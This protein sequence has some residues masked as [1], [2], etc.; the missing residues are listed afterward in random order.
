MRKSR[1]LAS[2]AV[3]G[4][5]MTACSPGGDS[6]A[7]STDDAG[8][9][10]SAAETVSIWYL[11]DAVGVEEAID[12]FKA[13][14]PD[15]EVD[16]QPYANDQYK[17]KLKVALGTENGPDVFHTWGGG[18]FKT[19]VDAG[20][21][22]DLGE[23]G[24]ETGGI[25]EAALKTGEFDGTQ[26]AVPVT[27]EASMV[28]YRTDV[29]EQLSLTPPKTWPEFL[30]VIAQTKDAGLV[31]I[32]MA[33]KPRWPGTHW[34]SELVAQSCGPDFVQQVTDGAASFDDPCVVKAH[35]HIQELVDAGAFNEG[36]NGLDYDPGE[37]R[38]LFWSGKAAMNHMGNWTVG[39]A[40][41]EAPEV[42]EKMAMFTLPAIPDAK[43]SN[44]AMTGG[45]NLFAIAEATENKEAATALLTELTGQEHA[46]VLAA[47]GRIPVRD[48]VEVDDPLLQQ[49]ADAMAEAPALTPWPDQ[50][51]DPTVAEVLLAQTQ[52]LFGKETTPE[53]AAQALAD[54]QA[55]VA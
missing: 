37:S 5:L 12:R 36:F 7:T 25:S 53:A 40:R 15:V 48:G 33:N 30:D 19:Y 44:A 45:T 21:V 18:E 8:G 4:V 32:A 14:N 43:V 51:L 13:D 22:A 3:A 39:S 26:Y 6:T 54:A 46:E 17:T 41:E 50:F 1:A 31:P 20:Q 35:G 52:A 9:D 28:W 34:W 2:V 11:A 24:A 10:G 23:L 42:L 29:F 49:V 27:V 16:A 47:G 55:K 38:Q